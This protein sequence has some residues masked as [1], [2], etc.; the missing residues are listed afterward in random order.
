MSGDKFKIWRKQIDLFKTRI[1]SGGSGEGYRMQMSHIQLN[2]QF[3]YQKPSPYHPACTEGSQLCPPQWN[4]RSIDQAALKILGHE[5]QK[6]CKE[7]HIPVPHKKQPYSVPWL[8]PLP[9]FRVEEAPPFSFTGVDFAGPLYVNEDESSKKVWICLYTCCVIR[10]VHIDH[11]PDLTTPSFINSFNRFVARRG[12][13]YRM[14]SDNSKTFEAARRSIKNGPS[15]FPWP[16]LVG[17]GIR[18]TNSLSKILS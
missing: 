16:P 14:L 12:R 9:N 6:S 10:A 3:S 4:E 1:G 15:M 8:P 13:S 17:R 11:V 7:N 18:A 5:Q 2:I